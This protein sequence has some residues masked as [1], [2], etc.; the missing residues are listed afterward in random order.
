[1]SSLT[2]TPK[3]AATR[4]AII[5]RAYEIARFAGHRNIQTTLRYIH[6]SGREL[7]AK[8]ENGMA[9]L[10]TLFHETHKAVPTLKASWIEAYQA[11]RPLADLDIDMF[12]SMVMLRRMALL[13]WIGSHSE[14]S[15]AQTHVRGFAE[16]TADLAE[17][18]LRGP[19]WA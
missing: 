9:A 3:G 19:I 16:G 12:D 15:L 13:A 14:T 10:W 11:V 4:D 6:L 17:R 1:M 8:F 7:A 18:Y 5:D 2:A